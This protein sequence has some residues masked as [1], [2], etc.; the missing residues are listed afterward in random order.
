MDKAQ[1]KFLEHFCNTYTDV[2][3]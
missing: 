2:E 3:N 1:H